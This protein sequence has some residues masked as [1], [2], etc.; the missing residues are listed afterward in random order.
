[1]AKRSF[2]MIPVSRLQKNEGWIS[3]WQSYFNNS[4]DWWVAQCRKNFSKVSLHDSAW[5]GVSFGKGLICEE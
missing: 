3:P 1:V 2:H 4:T 5:D